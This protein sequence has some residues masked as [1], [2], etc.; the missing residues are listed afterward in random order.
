MALITYTNGEDRTTD[1]VLTEPYELRIDAGSAEQSGD[2]YDTGTSFGIEKTGAGTL[3]LSGDNTYDGPTLVSAG[4]LVLDF[5]DGIDSASNFTIATGATL[6]FGEGVATA[7][8]GSIEGG[9]DID[10]GAGVYLELDDI[11]DG[12]VFSGSIFDDAGGEGYLALCGCGGGSLTLTGISEIG[13]FLDVANGGHLTIDGGSFTSGGTGLLLDGVLRIVNGG[14]LHT[15]TINGTSLAIDGAGSVATASGDTFLLGTLTVSNGGRLTSASDALLVPV[16]NDLATA[17]ITGGG[18]RWDI[19]G[20]LEMDV[21]I[22]GGVLTVADGGVAS[23]TVAMLVGTH[24]VINIGTG[25]L[26]GTIDTPSIV[27]DGQILADFTDASTLNADITGEGFLQKDG[28]GTLTLTG[29]STYSGVTYLNGGRL[30]VDGS[31]TSDVAVV[32]T[33]TLGG[34]GSVGTVIVFSG[35]TLAPGASTGSLATLDLTLLAG[36]RFEAEIAGATAG[37]GYDQVRVNGTVSIAGATLDLSILDLF[38]PRFGQSYTIVDNDGADAVAGTFA[39]YA[40]GAVFMLDGRLMTITYAGGDGNDIVVSK[41]PPPTVIVGTGKADLIDATHTVTGQPLPTSDADEIDGLGGNDT[42]AALGGD[43]QVTGGNGKDTLHGGDGSDWISGGK[44]KDSLYG[45]AGNDTLKGGKGGDVLRGGDGDDVLVG[46]PGRN[47]LSGGEGSDTFV[48]RSAKASDRIKDFADGD[49][50]ALA[51]SAFAGLG[52]T[53]TLKA[54]LF[55]VGA[56]AE[57]Q[58]QHVLYDKK[59]G[60]LLYARK[61]VD[62]AHPQELVKIGKHLDIDHHDI[63]VI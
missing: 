43:D 51:K 32:D 1:I 6:A 15:T 30:N 46:G 2:I 7:F 45:D 33:T 37:T 39:G 20:T 55:H 3:L 63:L 35:G 52:P 49:V 56:E 21:P 18:S 57:T 62:T 22:L 60:W 54:K 34:A 36:S 40:E 31:I 4:T 48:F 24:S 12:L 23:A 11:G 29:T 61:G 41:T 25:G 58:A 10:L 13:G 9:G 44:G 53:G 26:A 27:N 14:E 38:E 8:L 19:T 42:I 47:T 28:S 50:I 5:A 17:D 59:S 16:E